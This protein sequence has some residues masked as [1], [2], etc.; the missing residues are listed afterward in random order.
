[1]AHSTCFNGPLYQRMSDDLHLAGVSQR[2]H[3]G[4]QKVRYYGW[5]S[6]N[7]RIDLDM[8]RWLVWL[9]LGWTYWLG[10]GHAPQEKK[11]ELE[12]VRCAACGSPMKIVSVINFD[13]RTLV[14]HS[15]DYLDSG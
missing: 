5:M 2:T 8:V 13:C 10:S 6:P 15:L 14:E 7:S 1:M 3:D 4:Y 9:F 12:P 11:D